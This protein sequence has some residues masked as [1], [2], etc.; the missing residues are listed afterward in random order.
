[1]IV[2][3]IPLGGVVAFHLYGEGDEILQRR[4]DSIGGR[5]DIF[6]DPAGG[7]IGT[8]LVKFFLQI[9]VAGQRKARH[10][11]SAVQLLKRRRYGKVKGDHMSVEPIQRLYVRGER[12]GFGLQCVPGEQGGDRRLLAAVFFISAETAGEKSGRGKQQSAHHED[13]EG[14][15]QRSF[16]HVSAPFPKQYST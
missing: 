6:I 4:T 13:R 2:C 12:S 7:F 8:R 14:A 11:L 16:S 5:I 10:L 3:Q 9:C 15:A 1:M